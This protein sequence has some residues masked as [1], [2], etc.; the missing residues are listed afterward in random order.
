MRETD[1]EY[2]L[3]S[4]VDRIEKEIALG[5]FRTT[6]TEDF[7]LRVLSATYKLEN[8][9]NLAYDKINTIAIDLID[10]E[11]KIGVQVTAQKSNEKRKIDDTIN[12][13]ISEWKD[14]GVQ[15]LWILFISETNY[16]KK[17]IDTSQVYLEKDGLK[18]FIKTIRR[19][20]GDIN[21]QPSEDRL[22]IDELLKQETSTI[23]SGLSN[24]TIFKF[25]NK[26]EKIVNDNFFNLE[27]T[28]YFSKNEL[29]TIQFIA[30]NYSRGK[31][32]EYC[33][34]GNPCSGKTT[35][36]YSIIQ[37]INKRKVFYINLSNP[38]LVP[39]Q[40]IEELIQISHNYAFVIVDNIHDNI[41]LFQLIR[42]RIS[43][44]KSINTLY[45]SR[46]Y[47]TFDEFDVENIYRLIEE[48][49]YYRI[50]SNENFEE[51]VSG[52]IWKKTKSLKTKGSQIQWRKGN[53]QKILDNINRNLL[54]LNIA[55]R[56]WEQKNS[57]S[58]PI[59]FDE[60]DS[61]KIL[62]QFF[63]EHKL[64]KI[65]SDALY[66]YCLLYKNDI[67]FIPI[68]NEYDDNLKLRE[69]GIILQYFKSDF[70]F[71][72]HKEYAQL[73][74]DSFTYIDNGISTERKYSLVQN[75]IHYFD[76]SENKIR[77]GFILTKLHYS[78]DK[79]IIGKLL[80]D[81]KVASLIQ[82]EIK[83][84]DNTLSQVINVLNI[85]YL[86]SENINKKL[87]EDFYKTFVSFFNSNKLSL[88]V[89]DHYLAYTRLIQISSL[90]NIKLRE[91]FISVT[92]NQNEVANTNSIVELTWRIS[93]KNRESATILRIL[94]SYTFPEWL[95]MITGLPKLSNIT[96]SLSE[97]NTSFEAKKLLAGL[98]RNID[99]EKQYQNAKS[100]KIDQFVISLRAI[101]KIDITIGSNISKYFFQNALKDSLFKIKFAS[102]NLSEYSKALSDLSKLDSNFVKNQL[103]KDLNESIVYEKFANE[104]T[105]SNFTA[106]ALELRKHFEDSIKYFEVLNDIVLSDS[107]IQRLQ[108]E[109]NLNYLLIFTEFAEKY[110]NFED[111]ILKQITSKQITNVITRLPNKLEAL[112]NPKFLN[113]ENLDSTFIDSISPKEIEKY[114][115]TNK[116]TYAE[117]LFRVL[118]SIDKEKTIQKFK[119]L[120]KNILSQAFLDYELNFSQAL[121][122]IN[123]LK[124]KVYKDELCNGNIEIRG[125]L[126]TYLSIYT[127]DYRRYKRVGISD[128]FKGYYFGLLID[129]NTIESYCKSD[130]L[131]KLSSNNHNNIEIAS[132]F[133][134]LRRI[135]EETNGELNK[136][137]SRFLELNTDNFIQAIR[138]ED[139]T[140]TLSGLSELALTKFDTYGDDL[141]FR[142]KKSI[143]KKVEQR[144]N[145]K[146]YSV[147]LIPDLEKIA[148]NKGKTI[149]KEL[150]K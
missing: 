116:I 128:Y 13:T 35:F 138:N 83:E 72:P 113:V 17:N 46:Y 7:F 127:K 99:W 68:R 2:N 26:G 114:F 141:L 74:F 77:I 97:L 131:N 52:I 122:N 63:S 126:K 80:N 88:F 112:S 125:I 103:S 10:R 28:I 137:L 135:S 108:K 91:E 101:N 124:N 4:Y 24:L 57:L 132:V 41:N 48:M 85:I 34:L 14:K 81:E 107:F 106:R 23:Y 117:D 115:K 56:M 109:T 143:I 70:C 94:N 79:E 93:R 54:K 39:S 20:I 96:N 121:E 136:E 98:I 123:K 110:L 59:T 32:K 134:F 27:E 19:L 53:F 16:I 55:L 8:L 133:Q 144:K 86:H 44:F 42:E 150:K 73:I 31:L 18:V 139:I 87:L 76:T 145:D 12:D 104:P 43:K 89:D 45:L 146:I 50:D 149:L 78:E 71:F 105:I 49:K 75:Y 15:T 119:K 1:I 22:K 67:P 29:R 60:I 118:S 82:N 90:L 92:L 95:D 111:T 38:S 148:K 100:L 142:A 6:K 65:K 36:A 129:Q 37:K 130:F 66:T 3:L 61:N 51:K 140:K 11:K 9:E 30:E 25:L 64:D 69:K 5:N 147:K 33:I 120:D 84:A 62:H 58:N 102:A 21:K 47:K 40:V